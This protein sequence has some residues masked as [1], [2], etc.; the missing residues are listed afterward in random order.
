MSDDAELLRCY[1]E[2]G[3]EE[4]F[5]AFVRRHINLVYS[6]ALRRI[7]GDAHAA[8]DVT[9]QVF[10]A[11][12]QRPN[13]LAR[14]ARLSGWLYAT[15]RNAAIN[16]MRDE[17]RRKARELAALAADELHAPDRPAADWDR[18]RPVLDA[19]MD[20]LSD[21]DREAVLLRF[22][23]GLP[24][25]QIGAKLKVSENTARMR[26]ERA[27]DKLHVLLSRRGVTSTS[28]ALAVVLANQAV[29]TAPAGLATSVAGSAMSGAAAAAGAGT[30]ATVMYFMSA[31][32]VTFSLAAAGALALATA[33]YQSSQ[34]STAATTLAEARRGNAALAARFTELETSVDAAEQDRADRE[35]ALARRHAEKAAA[36]APPV[37]TAPVDDINAK[38]RELMN[39]LT[40][41]DAELRKVRQVNNRL[42]GMEAYRPL[43]LSLGLA[44][45]QMEQALDILMDQTTPIAATRESIQARFGADAAAQFE[46]YRKSSGERGLVN[47]FSAKLYFTDEPLSAQQASQ[48]ARIIGDAGPPQAPTG[49]YTSSSATTAYRRSLDWE[50]IIAQAKPLLSPAQFQGLRGLAAVARM[51][52]QLAAAASE[53]AT[54]KP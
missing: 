24:L 39:Q 42:R 16:L 11:A 47:E 23:A 9:Q 44:P 48:L 27:L 7:G 1:A 43:F 3:S 8:A 46:H 33:V 28:S 49:G 45:E 20:E 14:H 40:Q 36:V 10:L 38:Y 19:A 32:K 50:K 2:D 21:G 51:E 54:P 30:L 5:A 35:A 22:F 53:A 4:A 25:A 52:A 37:P 34:A 31:S 18:L 15:T 29:A 12:A 13:A 26:V 17:Q 41:N 6:A